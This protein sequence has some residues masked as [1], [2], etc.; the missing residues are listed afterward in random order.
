TAG[1]AT[2]FETAPLIGGGLAVRRVDAR[3]SGQLRGFTS[4]WLL[5]VG[6]GS[7]SVQGAPA[8][9][10]SRNNT[11]L[12]LARGGRAYAVLANGGDG[13]RCAQKLEVVAPSGNSCGSFDLAMTND[14]N[15]CDNWDLSLGLD[16]TVVQHLPAQLEQALDSSG[17]TKSCTIRFWP[18]ALK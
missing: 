12:A 3:A 8:W 15:T 17:R 18:A 4:S 16:G 5:T 10:T 13:E 9:M 2:W 1:P 7:A 6:S 11:N 14:G